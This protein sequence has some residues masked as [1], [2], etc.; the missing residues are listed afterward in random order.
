MLIKDHTRLISLI[1]NLVSVCRCKKRFW[2]TDG[3]SSLESEDVAHYGWPAR[4]AALVTAEQ[5]EAAT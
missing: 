4:S 2:E 3:L 5:A 1:R